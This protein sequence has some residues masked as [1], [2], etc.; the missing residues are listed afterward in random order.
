VSGPD[1]SQRKQATLVALGGASFVLGIVD[2]LF[3]LPPASEGQR[4]LVMMLGNIALLV[5]GFR[6]LAL[7]ARE[8]EIRRPTWLDVAIVLLAAIFVPYYLYKTRPQPRRL[9]AILAFFGL[10]FGCMVLTALG[11][12]V[13]ANLGG[14][15]PPTP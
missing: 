5:I 1:L 14:I 4:L 7:D 11:A 10:V 3:A 6:W 15:A 12:A 8:L 9:S 2:V 13:T